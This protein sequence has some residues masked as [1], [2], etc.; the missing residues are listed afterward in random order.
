[1]SINKNL[2]T[3]GEHGIL[4]LCNKLDLTNELLQ[5]VVDILKLVHNIQDVEGIEYESET[6]SEDDAD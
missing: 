5:E 6:N 2:W 1:M 4:E 3:V